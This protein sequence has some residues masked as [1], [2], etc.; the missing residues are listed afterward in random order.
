MPSGPALE[1]PATPMLMEFATT[2]CDATIDTQWTM[3]MIKATITRDA[4]PSTQLP[5]PAA[6]LC[7]ETLE[8][9]DQGYA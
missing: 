3:E 7:Q 5:E 6:Q 4:H 1:H 8:K 2:G 9:V